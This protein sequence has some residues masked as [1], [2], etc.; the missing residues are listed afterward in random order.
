LES[1]VDPSRQIEPAFAMAVIET[2]QGQTLEGRIL[3]ES[4]DGL[5]LQAANSFELP[6]RIALDQIE[7]RAWSPNS[8]MPAGLLNRL[9]MPGIWDLV[10]YLISDGVESHPAF[11]R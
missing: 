10:A 4:Q 2:V 1:L 8:L 11:G 7:H 5:M 3:E 9:D 6:R